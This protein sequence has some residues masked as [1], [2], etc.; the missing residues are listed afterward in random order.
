MANTGNK[1]QID[2]AAESVKKVADEMTRAGSDIARN[3]ADTARQGMESGLNT[4]RQ[5]MESGLNSTVHTFQ[6]V[7]DQFTQVL[8]F[9]GPQAEELARKSSQNIEAVSQA[10]S[11][12]AKGAQEI[13]S[14]WF[15]AMGE[16]V[17]KNLEAMNRLAGCRSVQD[18][19]TVQSEIVR[20]GLGQTVNSSRRI[21]E[22]SIRVADE[23]ARVIQS[24]ATQN[25]SNIRAAS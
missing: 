8:G 11:V 16:R 4:A 2:R 13:S 20:D 3:G 17:A 14:E 9:A 10:S 1:E 19:I 15:D 22:V 18:L 21:A 5:G 23:A 12:L 25:V 7:T 6:R 24:Q